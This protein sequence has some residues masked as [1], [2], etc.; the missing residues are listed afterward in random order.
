MFFLEGWLG[1]AWGRGL[2]QRWCRRFRSDLFTKHNY[3]CSAL[4][5]SRIGNFTRLTLFLLYV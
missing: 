4:T 5:T 3:P 1:A 2:G